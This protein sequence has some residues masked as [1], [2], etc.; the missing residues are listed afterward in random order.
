MQVL[1]NPK[2]NTQLNLFNTNKKNN[3]GLR[4]K[5]QLSSD[6]VSFQGKRDLL[7]L[8]VKTIFS[9]I[10]KSI[11]NK[12]NF[13]GQGCEGKVYKI[14]DSKYCVKIPC[15]KF[16]PKRVDYK[17]NF[18][19]KVSAQD[20]INHVVARL[21]DGAVIMK[22]I[23]GTPLWS[24]KMRAKSAQE[25]SETVANLPVASYQRFLKQISHA[26]NNGMI[27]DPF[28]HN[29]IVNDKKKKITVIDFVNNSGLTFEELNPLELMS[30]SLQ[31]KATTPLQQKRIA[32]NIIRASLKEF[33]PSHEPC[34]D[35]SQ[36]DFHPYLKMLDSHK[37]IKY[38]EKMDKDLSKLV[39]VKYSEL[40]GENNKEELS[41]L[42]RD[43]NHMI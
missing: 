28:N 31:N 33:K 27:F 23:E 36:F 30:F 40:Q 11:K 7:N 42:I 18:T 12:S 37:I 14:E 1:F 25:V 43:I 39:D 15:N 4:Y 21:G 32:K 29:V 3:H 38:N 19:K 9:R 17:S 13:L 5:P 41:S 16:V 2:Y 8:S 10:D 22:K 20:K 6:T 35:V 26:H 24:K 34:L